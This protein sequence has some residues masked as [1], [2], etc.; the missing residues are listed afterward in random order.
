MFDMG[1]RLSTPDG[2]AIF[3]GKVAPDQLLTDRGLFH[4]NEVAA[5][6]DLD[7]LR[8]LDTL[9]A[10]LE[11]EPPRWSAV[12]AVSEPCDCDCGRDGHCHR[13][14]HLN[15]YDVV[16]ERFPHSAITGACRCS[17]KVCA[18]VNS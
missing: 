7:A 4:P 8:D 1:Q 10:W 16:V 3:L 17:E 12:S 5:Y 15:L 6:V 13:L 18:C 14:V 11:E 2:E 9:E